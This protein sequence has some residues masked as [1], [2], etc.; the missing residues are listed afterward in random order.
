MLDDGA[1]APVRDAGVPAR[2][3]A[4]QHVQHVPAGDLRGEQEHAEHDHAHGDVQP[5]GPHPRDVPDLAELLQ[6]AHDG[7]ARASGDW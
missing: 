6:P 5:G 7:C 4:G 1:V 3:P 2:V